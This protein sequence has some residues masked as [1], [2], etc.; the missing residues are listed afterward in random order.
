MSVKG[1]APGASPAIRNPGMPIR[2]RTRP[3]AAA[4]IA[5]RR[6]AARNRSSA[7]SVNPYR[8]NSRYAQ[9]LHAAKPSSSPADALITATGT[10]GSR[11]TPT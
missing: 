10:A 7:A 6:I 11:M 9:R 5:S 1:S 3:S 8:K 2:N 4:G